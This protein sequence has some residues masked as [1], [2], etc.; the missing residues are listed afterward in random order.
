MHDL[1]PE[2]DGEEKRVQLIGRSQ[3]ALAEGFYSVVFTFFVLRPI[4]DNPL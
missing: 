3:N 2:P 1:A 4:Y